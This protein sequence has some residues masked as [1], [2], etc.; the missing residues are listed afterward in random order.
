MT[1]E[2]RDELDE[3]NEII[4]IATY[5]SNIRSLKNKNDVHILKIDE[6]ILERKK[7]LEALEKAKDI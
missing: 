6:K 2:E 7:Y 3:I 4:S 1:K 5:N